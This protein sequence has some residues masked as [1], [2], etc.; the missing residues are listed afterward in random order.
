MICDAASEGVYN[1]TGSGALPVSSCPPWGIIAKL[2]WPLLIVIAGHHKQKALE[3]PLV[4]KDTFSG[5]HVLHGCRDFIC[6]SDLIVFHIVCAF[7]LSHCYIFLH[8]FLL[9]LFPVW[10]PLLADRA[11][12]CMLVVV[13]QFEY[14]QTVN[15]TMGIQFN[16]GKVQPTHP[17]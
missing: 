12:C 1:E 11:L 17:Q 16:K 9:F 2:H 13:S 8:R 7:S 4:N 15:R 14:S 6:E 10:R 3:N 5:I